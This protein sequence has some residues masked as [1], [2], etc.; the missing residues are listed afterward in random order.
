MLTLEPPVTLVVAM[1]EGVVLVLEA[2][3]EPM[4]EQAVSQAVAAGAV[5]PVT[6]QA[7]MEVEAR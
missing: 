2:M 6:A 1:V 7:V 4:V 3:A 5:V